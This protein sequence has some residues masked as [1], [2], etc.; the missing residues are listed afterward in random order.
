M[1]GITSMAEDQS[2]SQ[3]QP[4]K[5]Q[6]TIVEDTT[7]AGKAIEEFE[8]RTTSTY[9]VYRRN[10]DFSLS[11]DNDHF[12]KFKIHMHP[13]SGPLPFQQIPCLLLLVKT[14]SKL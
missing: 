13:T 3:I 8:V 2:V 1:A 9:S 10:K 12:G 5:R 6:H 14:L 11:F 4:I 7:E